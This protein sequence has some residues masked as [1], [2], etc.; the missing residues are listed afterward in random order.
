MLVYLTI[1]PLIFVYYFNY[2]ALK[3]IKPEFSD[4]TKRFFFGSSI[5]LNSKYF[6]DRG[7]KYRRYTNI[8]IIVSILYLI[9]FAFIN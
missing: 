5:F 7:I 2:K 3:F 4:K 8:F 6:F 9:L 1:I